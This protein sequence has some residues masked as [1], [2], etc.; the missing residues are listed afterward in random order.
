MTQGNTK[1]KNEYFNVT[2]DGVNL[3]IA[4]DV[5]DDLDTLDLLGE[6]Q[7]GNVFAFSKLAKRM[8]GEEDYVRIKESLADKDGRTKVTDMS[9]FFV[10]TLEACNSDEAKN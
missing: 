10:K 5:M 6:V 3:K 9:N 2:V 4:K 8:F 1:P 7:D